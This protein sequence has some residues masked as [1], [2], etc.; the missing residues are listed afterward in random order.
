MDAV[1]MQRFLS[2]CW[3]DRSQ[4]ILKLFGIILVLVSLVV[5]EA[6]AQ[7]AT[8]TLEQGKGEIIDVNGAVTPITSGQTVNFTASPPTIVSAVA[9]ASR[10]VQVPT[11]ATA[12]ATILNAGPGSA[13]GC[14]I[15]V[16]EAQALPVLLDFWATDPLTN[17]ITSPP[18]TAIDIPAPVSGQVSSQTFVF[19]IKPSASFAATDV[20]LNYTCNGSHTVTQLLGINTLL[21]SAADNPVPDHIAVGLTPSNDAI[22]RIPGVGSTN[23]FVIAS[24]N[25]GIASTTTAR[26]RFSD[27]TM[28]VTALICETDPT[29]GQCKQTPNTTVTRSIDSKENTTWTAFLK[30]NG[31]LAL[32]PA[33]YRVFFEFLDSGGVIRGST[34]A[35]VMVQ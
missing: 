21:L 10:S 26:V 15:V 18:N 5:R 30:A 35:A 31:P 4:S 29:S 14:H 12:F 28:P 24:T 8:I 11:V 16:D 7:E 3:Q 23:I 19:A 20:R 2:D 22:V 6:V 34:S 9:P 1:P 13:F 32:D 33:K 25:I 27:V 17:A